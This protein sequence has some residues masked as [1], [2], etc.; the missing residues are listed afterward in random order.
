MA[1]NDSPPFL[2]PT[3]T[4][5]VTPH[6]EAAPAPP[7]LRPL[8]P[9]GDGVTLPN[10]IGP[11]LD[12]QI[13]GGA[14]AVQTPAPALAPAPQAAAD[15]VAAALLQRI[16]PELDRQISETIARVLHEQL[17]GFNSR[18]QKA[19]A[20]VVHEAVVKSFMQGQPGAD[21]AAPG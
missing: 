1:I 10:L 16:G 9:E 3:L 11:E 7:V 2:V 21:G 20:E 8:L 14:A 5:V 19:V 4:E 12:R 18:V 6:G 13:G 15:A 17:L